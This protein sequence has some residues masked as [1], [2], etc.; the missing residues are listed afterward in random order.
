M[1]AYPRRQAAEQI[2]SARLTQMP[3]YFD[4]EVSLK[5][6]RPRIWRRFLLRA[7]ATFK[8]LHDAIQRACGW[9]D[10]HLFAFRVRAT[11]DPD[12]DI[13]GV[14]SRDGWGPS[15]PSA[16][17]AR[18]GDFFAAEGTSKC[19]YVYDFGDAWWHEVKSRGIV[20]LEDEFTR[21]LLGGARAFPLEDSG[22]LGGYEDCVAVATGRL[23]DEERRE[24]LGGWDPEAFDLTEVK[25]RFDRGVRAVRKRKA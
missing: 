19:Y 16:A 13:A 10:Y 7:E 5:G 22:G 6:V 24:W 3:A 14:A 9:E 20:E 18:I 11:Y 21:R 1:T 8:Q 25:K 15:P 4:L 23:S 12:D 17:R 2:I